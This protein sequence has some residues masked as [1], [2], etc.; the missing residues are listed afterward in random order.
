MARF[1]APVIRAAAQAAVGF[2]LAFIA[3]HLGIP[4]DPVTALWLAGALT[5]VLTGLV[6]RGQQLLEKRY[7]KLAKYLHSPTYPAEVQRALEKARDDLLEKALKELR[8]QGP[9]S[10]H[11][12]PDDKRPS[13]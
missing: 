13:A 3:L 4:V 9:E 1:L 12:L 8:T 10:I 2:A 5:A 11:T 6:A 7:P